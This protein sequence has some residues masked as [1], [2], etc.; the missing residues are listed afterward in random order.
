MGLMGP[1]G[2]IRG[3]T[4]ARPSIL[5]AVVLPAG[6]GADG[7]GVRRADRAGRG[8]GQGR[9]RPRRRPTRRRQ[10]RPQH[11][12]P[13]TRTRLR[14][15]PPEAQD[16]GQGRGQ[17]ERRVR[18]APVAPAA[19]KLLE[20]GQLLAIPGVGYPN[21]NRSHFESMAIWHTARSDPEEHKG[22]GWLGRALDP[23]GGDSYT[24][25]TMFRGP[26]AA[27]GARPSPSPGSK[28]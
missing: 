6:P 16:R 20:A 13:A 19:D 24:I 10:R 25:R 18:P 17:A 7:A 5:P 3:L 4:H 14:E 15:A 28:T 27:G 22:Y 26:C 1:I 9:P 12:R 11:R 8:A 21:P 23:A 2:P